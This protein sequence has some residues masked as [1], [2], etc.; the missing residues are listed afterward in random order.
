MTLKIKDKKLF[1]QNLYFRQFY[2]TIK[3]EL[4]ESLC[5]YRFWIRYFYGPGS[6]IRQ[7]PDNAAKYSLTAAQLLVYLPTIIQI[8][9]QLNALL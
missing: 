8:T 4:Q 1:G 2:I 9:T 6:R 3:F 7:N 5:G